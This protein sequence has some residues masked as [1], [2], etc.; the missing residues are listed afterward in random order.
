VLRQ[1]LKHAVSLGLIHGN[2]A[3]KVPLPRVT[4]EE[5]HPLTPSEVQRFLAAAT[6]DRL[7][8]LFVLA[9]DSG[10]RQGELF[11]HTWD[12]LDEERGEISVMRSLSEV[13]GT[14]RVKETKT[15]KGR[16]RIPLAPSTLAEL[17]RH[18]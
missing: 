15:K 4:R 8:A 3:L 6:D 16:R 17:S 5:I 14:L 10:M 9:I 7:F 1:V 2:P 13:R 12:D 11:A 18:R